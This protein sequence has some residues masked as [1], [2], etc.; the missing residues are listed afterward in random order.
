[1][2]TGKVK[3]IDNTQKAP[4]SSSPSL[5]FVRQSSVGMSP[6][7]LDT[8]SVPQMAGNLAVQQLCRA[9]AIQAKLS[10]SQ[11]GDPDEQEADRIAEQVM[12][13][14]EPALIGSAPSTIQR[15]CAACEA[16][17]ATCPKC[18]EEQ[19]IQRK[20]NSGQA[21]HANPLVHSQIA[22]LRG[23][24]QP[25]PTSMRAFFEPRFG[26]D[27]SGV[28]VHT[29]SQA[30]ETAKTINARAFT[31]ANNIAFG[32]W[33]FAP[34]SQEGRRLLAHELTHVVQQGGAQQASA[35]QLSPDGQAAPAQPP[36]PPPPTRDRVQI[37]KAL[38]PG[39][40][41]NDAK[42]IT[43]FVAASEL[44]K[45]LLIKLLM[46]DVWVGPTG[47]AAIERCWGSLRDDRFV[48]F[49][50]ANKP[51]WDSSI[52]R[53]AELESLRQ[54]KDIVKAFAADVLVTASGYLDTNS[55][56]VTAE[57]QKFG[58]LEDETAAAAEPTKDQADGLQKLTEIAK[59]LRDLQ[60]SQ[61]KARDTVVGW[62]VDDAWK[63]DPDAHGLGKF[64]VMFD[65]SGRPAMDPD[66]GL[67][68][69][70]VDHFGRVVPYDL[71]KP[72][73]DDASRSIVAITSRYPS[74]YAL[75]RQDHSSV[76]GGFAGAT[77]PKIMREKLGKS[78]RLLEKDIVETKGKLGTDINPLDLVPI[79][80]QLF[81]GAVPAI[82]PRWQ[83]G[84]RQDIAKAQVS[85]RKID[86]ALLDA[87]LKSG[88][89]FAFLLAPLTGGLT[90][91]VLMTAATVA[92]GAKAFASAADYEA[93]SKA[94]TSTP[95]P[96][97]E[98]VDAKT[99]DHAKLVAD[100]DATAFA[101]TA[102]ALA[103][104]I[105][106]F[107][108]EAPNTMNL[109]PQ[110]RYLKVSNPKLVAEYEQLATRKMPSVVREV[111]EAER[112]TAGRVRL[113]QLRTEFDQL[114]AEV[115]N[116]TEL[117]AAQRARGN[118]IL[119]EARQLARADFKNL[120]T[121]V[122][123]RLRAD[124]ELKAIE[125]QLI[126]AGDV[127]D[128]ATGG[129]RLKTQKVDTK[130]QKAAGPAEFEPVNIEHRKRVSDNPWAAKD[131][132]NLLLTDATQN[133]QYLEAVRQYG[134]VWPADV[135]ED[136]VVRHQLNRQGIDFRPG[137]R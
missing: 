131:A 90:L 82:G 95:K 55:G 68:V 36:A 38:A 23:G 124:P 127:E 136:F 31:V 26:R 33:Q 61:E 119:I 102:V 37:D 86:Q 8:A 77:D 64:K 137:P 125:D 78:L 97:S 9:G 24:G 133:Q 22:A 34:A 118:E 123:K 60:Q 70:P 135:I 128:I 104:A 20:E 43:S 35:V 18:E 130:T 11:P 1:M 114:R 28:R 76:T 100:G 112:T 44:E 117:T 83:S 108:G 103:G 25:L 14:A 50:E 74:L 2:T 56:V 39:G 80:N 84:F 62:R 3:S 32:G 54:Y 115:G 13:M 113:A 5:T 6:G 67:E 79:H 111:L 10:I 12:R 21:P 19:T 66:P 120:Q 106:E 7:G 59:T 47:E 49:V 71:L 116:A 30:S 121:K 88:V 96:G 101:L 91:V 15:K 94:A 46:T 107:V 73:Y 65:P 92:T 57:M 53:G 40:T 126:A 42:D 122:M 99:V 89:Q 93:L 58:I 51:L 29:G 134:G 98:L 4:E 109:R 129:I 17:G 45:V 81:G 48:P 52:D 69:P 110:T 105:V 63:G 132:D 87:M 27:F 75:A 16:G 72:A 41:A 85:E